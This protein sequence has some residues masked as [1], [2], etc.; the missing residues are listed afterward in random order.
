MTH[1]NDIPT[2]IVYVPNEAGRE[3]LRHLV[4]GTA[5]VAVAA[6]E[7][8]DGRI[9]AYFEGNVYNSEC[10]K[11]F[12]DRAFHAASRLLERYPTI[13]KGRFD[14]TLLTPVGT[15]EMLRE[16]TPPGYEL[17]PSHL[18]EQFKPRERLQFVPSGEGADDLMLW[19]PSVE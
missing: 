2:L 18:Q 11:T 12:N 10:M 9:E 1:I 15:M 19:L 6:G 17:W 14:R 4:P 16:P 8:A 13:A 7:D 5:L 3:A